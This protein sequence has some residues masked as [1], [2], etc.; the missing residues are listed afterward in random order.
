[1][2]AVHSLG[3]LNLLGLGCLKL[4]VRRIADN[5]R[6]AATGNDLLV[7]VERLGEDLIT[8]EDHNDG[9]VLV[10]EGENTV[11][12]LTRHDS[13]AVQV[14]NFLDLE[15]TFQS[16]GELA[17]TAEKQQGFLVLEDLLAHILDGLV[18][19][20]D[21]LDL[22][23]N[24]VK[25]SHNFL[26]ALLLGGAVLAKREGEH[27]HGNELRRV[28]LGGSNTNLGAGVDVDTAVSEHGNGGTDNVND[29]DGQRATL[30]AVSQGHERVRSLTRLRDKH[31]GIVAEDRSL[32]IQK[33]G[34]KLNSDRNLCQ[35]FKDTTDCHAR[36]VAGTTSNEN[37][38]A[39][40]TDGWKVRAE[41]AEGNCL[42]RNVETT[43]HGVDN[44]LGLLENLLLHEV[45]KLA[46]HDLLEL[47]LKSLDG[48]D[49]RRAISLLETVDVERA[50]VN[51]SNIVILKVEDLLGVL[52]NGRRVR[53]EEELGGH[54]HTV[55]GHECTRLRAVQKR[56]VG[57][58][59][60][61]TVR[62]EEVLLLLKSHV[63]RRSFG[64]KGGAAV[65]TKLDV[66]K[67]NLHT[68]RS[69][70][71][72]DERRTLA[73]SDDLVG[74]VDGLDQQSVG[75]L[76]LLNNSLGKLSKANGL[77]LV[78]DVLGELGNAL[79]IS[80]GLKLEALGGEKGLKF[81]VVCNN[82]VVYD[83]EFP[84]GVGAA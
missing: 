77:V 17:A 84:S 67:V 9:Q 76:K 59:Q 66:D 50:L 33:I 37:D 57:G 51:V 75:T 82:T 55:V 36:V 35:L 16:S 13:L 21:R 27:D 14:R 24:V 44:R 1:M 63:L 72:N 32:A 53:R 41:T 4:G 70:D 45:V 58:T 5:N 49:V 10:N 52:D 11:L 81:L 31:T 56:L 78:V 61:S 34:G 29:T 12:E 30:Q 39:A 19:L 18:K 62:G 3:D 23:R 69:L 7:R 83:A 68:A 20:K 6:L 22:A 48:A 2:K 8:S 54:G 38:S 43:T 28:R 26:T 25:T 65:V 60:K 46:L 42:V 40:A 79:S 74:V 47:K 73:G 64:G 15:G 71:T 80:L